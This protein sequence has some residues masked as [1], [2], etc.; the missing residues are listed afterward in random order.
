MGGQ[1]VIGVFPS[2]QWVCCY[3][4]RGFDTKIGLGVHKSH[5]HREEWNREKTGNRISTVNGMN[6]GN[7]SRRRWSEDEELALAELVFILQ[8]AIPVLSEA[9]Q[10]RELALKMHGRSAEA[11]K[12]RRRLE[13]FQAKLAEV[14][15]RNAL[16]PVANHFEVIED[17]GNDSQLGDS[18][19]GGGDEI[20]SLASNQVEAN[21]AETKTVSSCTSHRT[22]IRHVRVSLSSQESLLQGMDQMQIEVEGEIPETSDSEWEIPV[23]QHVGDELHQ[24]NND[25]NIPCDSDLQ[26][27]LKND[28]LRGIKKLKKSL[29]KRG[30]KHY[31]VKR[32]V[33][34]L[35]KARGDPAVEEYLDKWLN[36]VTAQGEHGNVRNC[37]YQR[38]NKSKVAQG[39]TVLKGKKRTA[40]HA[41]IQSLYKKK[42]AKG[43][44]EY[45]FKDI[46]D[47]TPK[48]DGNTSDE[49]ANE[50]TPEVMTKYWSNIYMGSVNE[51]ES[52]SVGNYEDSDPQTNSLMNAIT[53]QDIKRNEPGLNKACGLDGVTPREWR[54][55]PGSVRAAFYNVILYHNIVL[56]RLAKARTIFIKKSQYPSSPSEFRPISITSVIQRQLHKIMA[57]RLNEMRPSNE[58]QVAFKNVDGIT[59]NVGTLR[60]V[61]DHS[62]YN[63]NDLH[64]VSMDMRKAFDTVKHSAIIAMTKRKG[65]P[66][67]FIEYLIKLY[68]NAKTQIQFEGVAVDARINQ[69]VFQGDPFSPPIF[70]LV[71]DK[72]LEALDDKFGYKVN[73]A[74][75]VKC[76]AFADDVNIIGG[77]VPGVQIN[78]NI[79]ARELSEIGLMANPGKCLSLSRIGDGKNKRVLTDTKNKFTVMVNNIQQEIKAIGPN[80]SWKY[81][82][83][84]FLGEKIDKRLPNIDQYLNRMNSALL[85]PQQK[86]E[87]LNKIVLP[88]LVHI[89]VF[90]NVNKEELSSVDKLVRR[91]VRKWLYIPHDTPTAYIHAPIRT[92]GLGIFEMAI[93]IPIIRFKRYSRFVN[94]SSMA[95]YI[96]E[97]SFFKNMEESFGSILETNGVSKVEDEAIAKIYIN[98]LDKKLCTKGLTASYECRPSRAWLASKSDEV[99]PSDFIKYNQV[100]SNSLPTLARRNWGRQGEQNVECRH[101]C[102]SR[103]TAH[104][105][106]QECSLAH[107]MRVKRHNRVVELIVDSLKRNEH[108]SLVEEEPKFQ[109]SE[110]M[111]KPDLVIISSNGEDALVIDVQVTGR[112][113]L[114]QRNAEKASK[115][116][117][118]VGFT[119]LVKHQYKVKKVSY[120]AVTISYVGIMEKSS[121]K[122]LK[123]LG[124]SNNALHMM[125]TSVLRGSWFCWAM[126]NRKYRNHPRNKC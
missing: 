59:A 117:K 69:G 20:E 45:I 62:S 92:G 120:A 75:R 40:E 81:L 39:S 111:R 51:G 33:K 112:F 87:V 23:S 88:K 119:G 14:A 104:H 57:A 94:A 2:A 82:G 38:K 66:K 101:G 93:R 5:A 100:S 54:K 46:D 6:N 15:Q 86:L 107:G 1:Q 116:E 24:G 55:I 49:L 95:E 109:T 31:R 97:T 113:E 17:H 121:A 73:E 18:Q 9:A 52:L 26:A 72:A 84:N 106:L 96:R 70:N 16:R 25:V 124:V 60:T 36:T 102:G 79:F 7:S 91:Y 3:C 99:T 123:K 32:L 30:I 53:Q 105:I 35:N 115:Y 98:A 103:E 42:R 58:Q 29:G 43:V 56:E 34:C 44:A 122:L 83:I 13:S 114:G 19:Y 68:S 47:N 11:I 10:N 65:L 78:I 125:T 67:E 64:I 77:S 21:Q 28:A 90:S 41:Y 71:L 85:K 4:D 61:I 110:G 108:N 80:T 37:N 50:I 89:A 12:G 22:S 63:R 8:R 27:K 126:F 48:A 76:T 74:T 118:I